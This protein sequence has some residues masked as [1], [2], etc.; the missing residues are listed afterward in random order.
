MSRARDIA[1]LQS[2]SVSFSSDLTVGDDIV[3][4]DDIFF[5]T[6]G[7][8]INFGI[9]NEVTL[10][11]VHDTGLLLN[12]TKQLQFGDSGTYI[13]Q[14]ADGVLDLVSDTEIEINATT[15]D[16]NG[17]VDINGGTGNEPIK[18]VST[19]AGSYIAFEDDDTTGSTRLGAIDNDF[20][21]DVNSAERVRINSSGN[22]GIG[23]ASPVGILTLQKDQAG[24]STAGTGTT[25]TF[26]GNADAG[27]PWEIYRDSGNTGDLV[28][29]QDASG[30]RSEAM[31]ITLSGGV[32]NIGTTSGTQ[33]SYFNSFLNVQNNASTGSHA[34][35][36]ITSGSG[37]YAGLHFGDSDNGRIG[38]VSYNNS[39]NS[40]LFTANNS[41]R[42]R[43]D[44]S[45]N[46]G[47]G[48]SSV[49]AKLNVNGAG[50][51]DNSNSTPV[52]LHINNSGSNDYASIYADTASAFKNL[53][54]NPDG[55][56]VGIGTS[57]SDD[58]HIASSVATIRLEDNDVANG[59]AYSK[60]F[61]HSHGGI[62]FSADPDG[63]RSSTDIRFTVDG[64][65]TARIDASGNFFVGKTSI[66]STTAGLEFGSNDKLAVTRDG[67]QCAAFVRLSS[68]G[69]I[70]ELQQASS[71]RGRI[72]INSNNYAYIANSA[73]GGAGVAFGAGTALIPVDQDG[74]HSDNTKDVGASSVR[75]DD[76]HATNGTIQTSDENEK[77]DIASATDKELSVAKKLSTLFKTFRWRDKVVEKGDKARTH[78]GIV[79]QE[80][81]L[82]FEAEGLDAT[83]YGLFISDT[84]TNDDGKEQTR[85]GVRYPELFSFIFSSIEAR[86][87]ALEGK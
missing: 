36:T 23:T 79:A 14:S 33:P 28:F 38:Q 49:G 46:V 24:S 29:C 12:S 51:F 17:T 27:N 87:T 10:T 47:I 3:V 77:Q 81:K 9:N 6:D 40:L 32:V 26:N 84:W 59:E 48:T 68:T 61:T 75:F 18:V 67:A 39:D 55:G 70:I 52:R 65:E 7:S 83:K 71:V 4:T 82:A 72:G 66:S 11:H 5:N 22:V 60:I 62:E 21:I 44:S 34:S 31:R 2:G 53:V 15:I 41:E 13:H 78:T 80:V 50:R 1:N 74:A 73:S 58:L 19:D 43:I 64:S 30:T 63:N 35:I 8:V 20:K 37:G 86:L 85:L 25:L 16:I 76:V 54:I 42:M 56:N 69:P 45:G 57:P